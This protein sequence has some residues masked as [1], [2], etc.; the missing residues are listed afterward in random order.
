M[1]SG[2]RKV[3]V[4]INPKS[5]LAW[6]FGAMQEVLERAWDMPDVDLSY[7]FSRSIEDGQAKARRAVDD[8]VDTIIVVGGDGMINS[9]GAVLVNT[10]TALGVIPAGS[11]NGFAR[12]FGVPLRPEQ[13]AKSLPRGGRT[14]IDAGLVNDRHFFVTCSM[15]WDAALVR[16]YE[17]SP[18]R[19]ILPYVFSAVSEFLNYHPQ[20]LHVILD[21]KEEL[22]FTDPVVFTVANLSQYGGGALIA[23]HACADDGFLELIVLLKK[24]TARVLPHITRLFDGSIRKIP[25]GLFRRFQRLELRRKKKAPVQVDGELV[26]EGTTLV[27]QVLPKALTIITPHVEIVE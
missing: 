23:P 26:N 16:S 15:A 13:A 27:V 8:G 6:S 12:H 21:D 18:I 25:D 4:L 24:D 17:K 19:G 10:E 9:I 1:A 22:E 20:P 2:L 3:R 14:K 5:G 7:Q 11:G